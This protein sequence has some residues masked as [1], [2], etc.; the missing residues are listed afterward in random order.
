[1]A[2]LSHWT[3]DVQ[4]LRLGDI[5][6]DLRYRSVHRGGTSYEL[7]Q[8]CFDLLVLFLR[9]PGVLQTREAIFRQVWSG[10]VVEDASLTNCIWLMRRAFGRTA[11][12][13]IRTVP[14]QGYVFDPPAS[15]VAVAVAVDVAEPAAGVVP[16]SAPV[17]VESVVAAPPPR[18][19]RPWLA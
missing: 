7:N 12:Q 4:R 17:V 19:R 9:E 2:G 3:P 1:M 11:K 13:W 14:K 5:E 15:V 16:E 18:A 10:A 8:R 6:I